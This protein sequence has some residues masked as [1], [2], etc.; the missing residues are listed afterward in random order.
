MTDFFPL[1]GVAAA[2][3]GVAHALLAKRIVAWQVRTF[4]ITGP[5]LGLYVLLMRILGMALAISGV[6]LAYMTWFAG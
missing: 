4:G 1:L 5:G 2:V 6:Y 3:Y